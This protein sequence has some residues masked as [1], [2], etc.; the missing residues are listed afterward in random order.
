MKRSGSLLLFFIFVL[1]T[2]FITFAQARRPGR[3]PVVTSDFAHFERITAFTDGQGAFLR[4]DMTSETGNVG[5]FVYRVGDGG[6]VQVSRSLIQGSVAKTGLRTAYGERY[7]YFDEQ[8]SLSTSYVIVSMAA[9]GRRQPT[10]PFSA[11][12]TVNFEADT[13]YTKAFLLDRAHNKNGRLEGRSLGLTRELQA[14]VNASRQTPD[15]AAQ[16]EVV[17]QTGVKI[18]VKTEGMYRVSRA[19]LAAAG[20][21]VNGDSTFWRLF[22]NGNEQA[23]IV[24]ADNQYI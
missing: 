7:E 17:S 13:G 16:R 24:G 6:L 21:D 19:E 18:A 12:F 8:G 4:W 22:V 10:Q 2:G 3:A 9:D 23:I 20:F 15:P 1:S 5:F 11:K 14:T